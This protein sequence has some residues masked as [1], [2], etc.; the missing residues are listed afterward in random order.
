MRPRVYTY[1][2]DGHTNV[3]IINERY[4]PLVAPTVFLDR[5]RNGG[6]CNSKATAAYELLFF[7]HFLIAKNIT[8]EERIA[9]ST[10]LTNPEAR[11]FCQCAKL[12]SDTAFDGSDQIPQFQGHKSIVPQQLRV[13]LNC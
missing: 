11:T 1:Q 9:A 4:I 2:R 8:I 13:T 6:S 3:A 12:K 7:L 10:M 5:Y